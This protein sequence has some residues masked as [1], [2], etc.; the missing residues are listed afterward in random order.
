MFAYD[1]GSDFSD[2]SPEGIKAQLIDMLQ[3]FQV[4]IT[5]VRVR[6]NNGGGKYAHIQCETNKDC[7][8]AIETCRGIDFGGRPFTIKFD[9]ASRRPK[10]DSGKKGEER[11][12]VRSEATR[13]WSESDADVERERSESGATR[14]TNVLLY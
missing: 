8:K 10:V 1:L 9:G 4:N 14:T 6:V 7:H 13:M 5:H 11:S 3:Y 2:N 12:P